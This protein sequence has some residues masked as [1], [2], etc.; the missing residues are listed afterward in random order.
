MAWVHLPNSVC[1]AEPA[2]AFSQPSGCLAG[3][4]SATSKK[5][6]TAKRSSKRGSETD[7]STTLQSGTTCEPSMADRG[8]A[9]WIASLEDSHASRSVTPA[10]CSPTWTLG[11]AGRTRFASFVRFGPV[12]FFWRT[13]RGCFLPGMDTSGAYSAAWPNS[14][15]MR[16]G[17]CY[18]QPAVERHISAS[19][20]G[21]WPTPN[22]SV[23]NDGESPRTWL[24]RAERLKA[25]HKNGNGAGMPLSIAVQL[26]PT[27]NAM[28]SARNRTARRTDANSKHHGGTTLADFV[29][30]LDGGSNGRAS[31]LA[32]GVAE[33][34]LKL[35]PM[36]VAWLM[37]WPIG[38]QCCE[39]LATAKF[40]QWLHA[41]GVSCPSA[42]PRDER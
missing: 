1:S 32:N 2:A 8:A 6:R 3:E 36:W 13:Y 24:E 41:H 37:G 33:V 17:A 7:C 4:P 12:G 30:I 11:T 26:W 39:P 5:S 19:D 14:G 29:T 15:S 27:P 42:R 25:K 40:Q 23:A 22:A 20:S 35:N 9:R 10:A 34:G 18:R 38:W 28:S 16:G 21:S 31:A